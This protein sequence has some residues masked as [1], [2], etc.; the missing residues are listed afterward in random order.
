MRRLQN[1]GS[2]TLLVE[3]VRLARIETRP[4]QNGG[5]EKNLRLL[6]LLDIANFVKFYFLVHVNGGKALKSLLN[7]ISFSIIY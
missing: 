2:S 6:L 4:R 1:N 3:K 5:H 7:K